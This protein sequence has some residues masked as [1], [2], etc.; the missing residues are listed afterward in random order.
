MGLEI[1]YTVLSKR[2]SSSGAGALPEAMFDPRGGRS[3][4][5]KTGSETRRRVTPAVHSAAF[6][7]AALLARS[8]SLAEYVGAWYKDELG[9]LDEA[10]AVLTKLRQYARE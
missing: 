4:L 5:R 3:R 6:L 9:A 10:D 1:L 8:G 7:E 2:A